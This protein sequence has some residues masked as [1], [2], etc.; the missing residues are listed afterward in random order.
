MEPF[1]FFYLFSIKPLRSS[2]RL[3]VLTFI[4]FNCWVVWQDLI[5][6]VYETSGYGVW[7]A[8]PTWCKTFKWIQVDTIGNN[9]YDKGRRIIKREIP[10]HAQEKTAGLGTMP[11]YQHLPRCDLQNDNRS[12]VEKV[13]NGKVQEITKSVIVVGFIFNMVM[14]ILN[15]KRRIWYSVLSKPSDKHMNVLFSEYF[16]LRVFQGKYFGKSCCNNT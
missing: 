12:H 6:R 16:F 1:E 4:P 7:M 3:H 14:Y 8:L 5:L 9:K 2:K 13:F 10:S 15:S 11:I